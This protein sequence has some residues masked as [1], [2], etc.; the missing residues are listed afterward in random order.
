VA[1]VEAAST[2][3]S[4]TSSFL[5]VLMTTFATSPGQLHGIY[6]PKAQQHV[7]FTELHSNPPWPPCRVSESHRSYVADTEVMR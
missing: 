4:Q 1:A 7:L 3:T 5:P 6:S 2:S